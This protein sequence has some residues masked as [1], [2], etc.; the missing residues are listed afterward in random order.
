MQ[1]LRHSYGPPPPSH[2]LQC[3][4]VVLHAPCHWD[5]EKILP[6]HP[7]RGEP[8]VTPNVGA[9]VKEVSFS[10]A[11]LFACVTVENKRNVTETH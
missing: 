3:C 1:L 5:T 8:A 11:T 2:L 6:V 7:H 10:A 4:Q 9:S